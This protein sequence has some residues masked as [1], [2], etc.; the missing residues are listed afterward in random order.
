MPFYGLSVGSW[1]QWYLSYISPV[2][3]RSIHVSRFWHLNVYQF[4]HASSQ[5]KKILLVFDTTLRIR[6]NYSNGC[7]ARL[8]RSQWVRIS[9]IQCSITTVFE[10]QQKSIAKKGSRVEAVTDHES[11]LRNFVVR[12]FGIAARCIYFPPIR[13][14]SFLGVILNLKFCDTNTFCARQTS[15]RRAYYGKYN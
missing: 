5:K 9:K 4:D 14:P 2:C 10:D 12:L 7:A 6:A 3:A 15:R 11:S 8:V 1:W 13:I